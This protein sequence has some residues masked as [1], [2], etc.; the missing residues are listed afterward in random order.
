[1]TTK[2][3]NK[4]VFCFLKA[5]NDTFFFVSLA[6]PVVQSALVMQVSAIAWLF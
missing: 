4:V 6:L 3:L 2:I 5:P 1:M